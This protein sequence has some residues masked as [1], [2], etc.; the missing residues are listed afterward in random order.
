MKLA[1]LPSFTSLPL[2]T[3]ICGTS[4][5]LTVTVA[6]LFVDDTV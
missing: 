1:G 5:S 3:L 2:R 6:A 4:S